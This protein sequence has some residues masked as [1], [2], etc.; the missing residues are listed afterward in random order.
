MMNNNIERSKPLF[1]F[2]PI[3][4]YRFRI[5]MDQFSRFWGL[6]AVDILAGILATTLFLRSVSDIRAR[7]CNVR[8][9]PK[10]EHLVEKAAAST[11]LYA[12]GTHRPK[13]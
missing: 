8:F 10:S 13:T 9:T 4:R 5:N 2:E 3:R 6:R 11:R 1:H 7:F 12:A